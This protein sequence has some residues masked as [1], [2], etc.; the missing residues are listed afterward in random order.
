MVG[1]PGCSSCSPEFS[2]NKLLSST[3][4]PGNGDLYHSSDI[5]PKTG[6]FESFR[7]SSTHHRCMPHDSNY[8]AKHPH[9]AVIN[10]HYYRFNPLG[11]Y[12]EFSS[13]PHWSWLFIRLFT[14]HNVV[15][16]DPQPYSATLSRILR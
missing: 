1:S 3:R 15:S 6:V 13:W 11:G 16:C 4:H 14:A 2:R 10:K 7:C 12:M 8:P 9:F 5:I